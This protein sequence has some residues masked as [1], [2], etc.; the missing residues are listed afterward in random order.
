MAYEWI[1]E[2]IGKERGANKRFGEAI[3]LLP[4]HVSKIFGGQ[5]GLYP[6][7]GLKAARYL[8]KT[9]EWIFRGPQ[10]VGFEDSS[11]QAWNGASSSTALKSKAT[12]GKF[13]PGVPPQFIGRIC[14]VRLLDDR[15]I[16]GLVTL[17]TEP[18]YYSITELPA[19]DPPY[20]A[21]VATSA[22]VKT[23]AQS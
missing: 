17:G 5:R 1:K 20:E 2:A 7:E 22:L 19:I 18:G 6:E 14:V 13:V 8:G 21:M 16:L 12:H 23:L 11:T 10:E 3:G 4:D 15:E 9:A